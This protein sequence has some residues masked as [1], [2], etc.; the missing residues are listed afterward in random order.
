MPSYR[1]Y[2]ALVG[3]TF[4]QVA[5]LKLGNSSSACEVNCSILYF[6]VESEFSV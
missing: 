4:E 1:V 6:P 2:L 5:A 3:G